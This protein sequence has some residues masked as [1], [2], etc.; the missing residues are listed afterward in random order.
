MFVGLKTKIAKLRTF[1]ARGFKR[2]HFSL[3][4]LN[5]SVRINFI[6]A[7][8]M[9]H[10]ADSFR[11]KQCR[12]FLFSKWITFIWRKNKDKIIEN[13]ILDLNFHLKGRKWN[14]RSFIS[15]KNNS[16]FFYSFQICSMSIPFEIIIQSRITWAN[17]FYWIHFYLSFISIVSF[18]V[19]FELILS[20]CVPMYFQCGDFLHKIWWERVTFR[21][22]FAFLSV[23]F[24]FFFLL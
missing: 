9:W 24:V 12:F 21:Q 6:S 22:A 10:G 13:A 17:A 15:S 18:F 3:F 19:S 4:Q 8:S 11:I 20:A 16:I 2:N 23:D 5:L 1:T 14:G 7:A